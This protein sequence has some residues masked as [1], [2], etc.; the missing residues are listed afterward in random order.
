MQSMPV[1]PRE[2]LFRATRI[3]RV[4][5]MRILRVKLLVLLAI[6]VYGASLGALY[7]LPEK[8]RTVSESLRNVPNEKLRYQQLLFLASKCPQM[9]PSLKIDA[10]KVPGC[11]STVH[12]HASMDKEGKINFIGDSDAQL[13]KGLVALLVNGLS[14]ETNEV[15]QAVEPEFI[16]YAGITTSLTPGRNNGFI[17]MLRLMKEKSWKISQTGNVDAITTLPIV[18]PSNKP[19]FDMIVSKLNMLKPIELDLIDESYKHA[20]HAGVKIGS[21][22]SHFNLKVTATCFEGLSLVQ[23]HRMIYSLLGSEIMGKIHAL[24]ISAKAPTE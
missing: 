19:V 12:V 23:R 1:G 13:T 11:L 24:V 10:N 8:L 16:N 14:G 21:T 5:L 20:N 2:T 7:G 3:H 22:E 4:K 6:L 18:S 17:N 9:D 15:I